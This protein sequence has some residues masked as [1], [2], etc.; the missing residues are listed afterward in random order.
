MADRR[1]RAYLEGNN[2][3]RQFI[4]M[5]SRYVSEHFDLPD[6]LAAGLKNGM[7]ELTSG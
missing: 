2:R 7:S 4:I 6:E 1:L 3:A 5:I